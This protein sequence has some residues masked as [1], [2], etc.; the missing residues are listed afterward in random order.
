MNRRDL[1][2]LAGAG[3]TSVPQAALAAPTGAALAA[4]RPITR[5]FVTVAGRQVHYR[6]AGS[7]PPVF[8]LHASPGSSASMTAVMGRLATD[9]TVIAP[10]TPGN[11]QSEPLPLD[12]PRMG[13]YADALAALMTALGIAKAGIYGS[14][15]GAGC[16]LEMSRRHPDRVSV[17]IVNGYLHFTDAERDEILANYLPVLKPDWYGGHLVWAWGRIRE[18]LIFFPWFRKDDA[19][20]MLVD[21]PPVAGIHTGVVELLRSGDNYRKPYRSAFTLD[22]GRAVTEA[23]APTVITTSQQ[24]VMWF[25]WARMPPPPASVTARGTATR[26][27]SWA[28][29]MAAL[30]AHPGAPSTSRPP[31]SPAPSGRIGAQFVRAGGADLYLR[32]TEGGGRPLLFVHETGASSLAADAYMRALQGRRACIAVDLPGHGESDA[33]GGIDIAASV[34]AMRA[35]L[36]ALGL[37]RADVVGLGDGAAVAVELAVQA[38]AQVG[39]LILPDVSAPDAGERQSLAPHLAPDLAPRPHGAH[40]LEAWNYVRDRELWSPW[41]VQTAPHAI[42]GRDP[43]LALDSLQRRTL[44]L[45]KARDVIAPVAAERLGYP[46]LERLGRLRGT[47]V[48]G[49]PASAHTERARKALAAANVKVV[50]MGWRDPERFAAVVGPL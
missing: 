6:R 1:L 17:A 14:Y 45:L 50:E 7:G 2:I 48:L 23:K 29:A 25:Q 39:A 24:D 4:P 20:R 42:R 40:L 18:Q 16:A 30:K 44:D 36:A 9:F 28:I 47:V 15:T 34:R 19:S 8:L 33:V 41:N 43:D 21:Q 22:Y 49:G 38:P 26:E 37:K 3:A 11:G 35:V 5:H 13:D 10:D 32:R 31:V 27:E 12:D 46:M